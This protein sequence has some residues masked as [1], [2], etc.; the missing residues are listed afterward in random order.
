MLEFS[1]QNTSNG[2]QMG[3][4]KS[5]WQTSCTP[6]VFNNHCIVFCSWVWQSLPN[7]L[8]FTPLM[9]FRHRKYDKKKQG[10]NYGLTQI[11]CDAAN[12]NRDL[13]KSLSAGCSGTQSLMY[14]RS[15]T[16]GLSVPLPVVQSSETVW[17]L[18]N[19]FYFGWGHQ[20]TFGLICLPLHGNSTL[21]LWKI[22]FL[23]K[24]KRRTEGFIQLSRGV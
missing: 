7:S 13:E 24:I 18:S 10:T 20:L 8:W 6:H 14:W 11:V 12:G 21:L 2:L 1:L 3:F 15:S 16:K 22:M 9:V 17:Q 5:Q 4:S 23:K 19:D